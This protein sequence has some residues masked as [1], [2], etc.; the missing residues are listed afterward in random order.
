MRVGTH[1]CNHAAVSVRLHCWL[2]P[3]RPKAYTYCQQMRTAAVG[4]PSTALRT[5]LALSLT[6]PLVSIS[7]RVMQPT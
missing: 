1:G 3:V 6:H 4:S 7:R 2:G 5:T